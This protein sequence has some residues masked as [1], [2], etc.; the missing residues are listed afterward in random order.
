MK[1]GD[2]RYNEW[3]FLAK[4]SE[5]K[6]QYTELEE[7]DKSRHMKT[8]IVI[9]TETTRIQTFWKRF[10]TKRWSYKASRCATKFKLITIQSVVFYTVGQNTC[11]MLLYN[12]NSVLF[13][14]RNINHSNI[15]QI[16]C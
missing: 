12:C 4:F 3:I 6:D 13:G 7:V 16:W 9:P 2:I 1:R 5:D 11:T 15:L 10:S 14:M 8:F